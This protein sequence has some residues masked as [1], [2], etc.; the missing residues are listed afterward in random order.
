MENLKVLILFQLYSIES[1]ARNID[2]KIFNEKF[3]FMKNQIK[4]NIIKMSKIFRY[5][6][7]IRLIL[8]SRKYINKIIQYEVKNNK[9]LRISHSYFLN[10]IKGFK[11]KDDEKKLKIYI[12]PFIVQIDYYTI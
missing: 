1:K 9:K 8:H 4:V 11:F 3:T 2:K 6:N 7:N 10:D 12:S 5:L